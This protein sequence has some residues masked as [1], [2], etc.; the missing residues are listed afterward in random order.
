MLEKIDEKHHFRDE[1][2]DADISENDSQSNTV[3]EAIE[4][5]G[6][7]LYDTMYDDLEFDETQLMVTQKHT[8]G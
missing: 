5:L 8:R 3:K 6:R 1:H 7:G 4:C 2:D